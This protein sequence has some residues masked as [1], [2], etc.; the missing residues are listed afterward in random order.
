MAERKKRHHPII[1]Q[2]FV[3]GVFFGLQAPIR[4]L[5]AD[6]SAYTFWYSC[7]ADTLYNL[8]LVVDGLPAH[9]HNLALHVENHVLFGAD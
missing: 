8:H 9:L 6:S 5:S 7:S 2:K 3:H 4:P 1:S